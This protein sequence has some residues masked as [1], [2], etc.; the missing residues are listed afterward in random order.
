MAVMNCQTARDELLVADLEELRGS[1][2]S[3]LAA[4]LRSCNECRAR[5]EMVLGSHASLDAALASIGSTHTRERVAPIA[6]RRRKYAWLPVP[7][8]AAAILALLLGR[9]PSETLPNVDALARLMRPRAP[10]VQPPAGKQAVIMEK[11]DMTIVWL[12]DQERK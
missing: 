7:L 10:V 4:H 2:S 1:G 9:Q 5:A 3:E 11:S 12:Y 6:G 8:A